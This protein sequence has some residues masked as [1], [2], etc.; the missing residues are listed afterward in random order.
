MKPFLLVVLPFL[1][2]STF[3]AAQ[4]SSMIEIPESELNEYGAY[5]TPFVDEA[6]NEIQAIPVRITRTGP[7]T[8]EVEAVTTDPDSPYFAARAVWGAEYSSDALYGSVSF[9][10]IFGKFTPDPYGDSFFGITDGVI[11]GLLVQLEPG[12]AGGKASVGYAGGVTGAG[13]LA[14]GWALKASAMQTWLVSTEFTDPGER[15]V[16]GEV[17]LSALLMKVTLGLFHKVDEQGFRDGDWNSVIY[18]VGYGIGF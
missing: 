5:S 12:I 13:T 2:S 8:V 10:V 17:T 9:G 14:V 1:L 6:G 11:K 16:G 7:T 3:A 18:R 15:F 4:T